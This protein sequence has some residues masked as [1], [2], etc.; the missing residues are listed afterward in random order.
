MAVAAPTRPPAPRASAAVAA[1]ATAV[2]PQL[3]ACGVVYCGVRGTALLL[4]RSGS[5]STQGADCV[6]L[7]LLAVALLFL[8]EVQVLISS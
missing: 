2:V 3:A 5:Q 1:A 7:I 6:V 4:S 8:I